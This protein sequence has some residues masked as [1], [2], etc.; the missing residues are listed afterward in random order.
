MR[1]PVGLAVVGLGRVGS[2]LAHV[3]T[4]APG[5]ELRWLCDRRPDAVYRLRDA[6][7]RARAAGSLDDALAD[8]AVDAVVVATPAATHAELALAA[9]RADKHVLVN[10]P[11]ALTSAEADELA[12][13][14]ERRG[15]VLMVSNPLLWHP[16]A[17]RLHDLV[18]T[19]RLG[20]LYYLNATTHGPAVAAG[21][22]PLVCDLGVDHVALA[23]K[24]LG[25][26][27]VEVQVQGDSYLHEGVPDVAFCSLRFATGIR[28]HLHLSRLDAQA[29]HRLVAVGSRST[30]V[31]QHA[32]GVTQIALHDKLERDIV[33]PGLGEDA[34]LQ[35]VCERFVAAVRSAPHASLALREAVSVV[36]VVEALE[37]ALAAQWPADQPVQAPVER[38]GRVVTLVPP[39]AGET[40]AP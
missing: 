23:L 29:C 31:L 39:L 38:S 40:V 21:S 35:T 32:R 34:S 17:L 16:A 33:I 27:P 1:S 20:E 13:T 22:D 25:D 6:Y 3:L 14:A 7:P 18:A 9:L 26:E 5:V 24:L 28:V 8:D 15:R 12:R 19:G 37:H 30:A 11:L 10:R 36:G 4:E 2:Q